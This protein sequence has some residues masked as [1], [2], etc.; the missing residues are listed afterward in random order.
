[1]SADGSYTPI[2]WQR[3]VEAFGGDEEMYRGMVFK[4]DEFTF[5]DALEKINEAFQFSNWKDIALQADDISGACNYLGAQ[6]MEALAFNLK[7]A[8]KA[9]D[10]RII[11]NHYY[12]FLSEAK[13]LKSYVAKLRGTKFDSSIIDS[14]LRAFTE[15]IN[16][17]GSGISRESKNV[18]CC[19]G[20]I[21]C[22]IF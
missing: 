6:K 4:F 8:A 19:T 3:G 10:K 21:A 2:N 17:E 14:Y 18:G 13:L 20:E 22:K 16:F 11:K 9:S 7:Q 5:D 1:M 12:E 15:D